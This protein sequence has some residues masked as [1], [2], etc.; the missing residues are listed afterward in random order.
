MFVILLL[1]YNVKFYLILSKINSA[2]CVDFDCD[3][4]KKCMIKDLDG[5]FLG[6]VGTV[7]PD[8]AYAWDGDARHGLGDYR[9]PSVMLTTST[10]QLIDVNSYA[11]KKGELKNCYCLCLTTCFNKLT[12]FF[13]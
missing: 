8:S 6:H 3:A 11:P 12:N 2:D 5:T 13:Y 9:I 1:S 7:L 4:M 10:G